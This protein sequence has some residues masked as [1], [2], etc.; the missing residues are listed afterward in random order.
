VAWEACPVDCTP[1]VVG[2]LN[3]RFED[4]ADN[5]VDAIIDLLEEINIKDLSH[6]FIPRHCS[7]QLKGAHWTF[8][9]RRGGEW[10]YLQTDYLLATKRIAKRLRRVAFWLPQYHDS[11]HHAV[12][13][14]FNLEE[15]S[16]ESPP[17][18][19][20]PPIRP[21]VCLSIRPSVCLEYQNTQ[22]FKVGNKIRVSRWSHLSILRPLKIPI[23]TSHHVSIVL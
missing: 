10:C 9:M 21:S 13:A 17:G 11:D 19:M 2:D 18:L 7:Q 23:P 3:I 8:R 12:D 15:R 20:S 4:L 1:L 5:R 16:E 6:T 22:I 14:T